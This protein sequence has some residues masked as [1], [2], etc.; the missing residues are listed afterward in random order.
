MLSLPT[1]FAL[2]RHRFAVKLRVGLERLLAVK[3]GFFL[4][5]VHNH[6]VKH[7]G[8]ELIPSRKGS[9]LAFRPESVFCDSFEIMARNKLEQLR[10]DCANM[11]H[12]LVL[13]LLLVGCRQTRHATKGLT[14][15]YLFILNRIAVNCLQC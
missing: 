3:S 7:H 1:F 9:E 10:K 4:D 6:M 8:H 11:R 14:Q 15:A 5:V 13:L 12:G 2:E